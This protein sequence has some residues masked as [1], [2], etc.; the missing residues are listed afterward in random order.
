MA[1]YIPGIE[2]YTPTYTPFEPDFKFAQAVLST[3]QDRYDTNYKQ[4][5]DVYGSVTMSGSYY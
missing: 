1:T 2:S 3:R 5:N 4:L